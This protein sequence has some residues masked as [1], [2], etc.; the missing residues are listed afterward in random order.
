MQRF[1]RPAFQIGRRPRNR[2]ASSCWQKHRHMGFAAMDSHGNAW[3]S[4]AVEGMSRI[5]NGYF[6][7]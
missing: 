5:S 4:V 6:T 1:R 7:R 3:K 2:A